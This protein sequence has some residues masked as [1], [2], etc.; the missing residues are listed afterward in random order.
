MHVRAAAL[1]VQEAGVEGGE[2]VAVG[3]RSIL[4]RRR[5]RRTTFNRLCK[6]C[7]QMY[8]DTA[9]NLSDPTAFERAYD[10]HARGV[11]R[12]AYRV[13]GNAAQAQDVVQD[14][15]LKLWR[16]P[17][18]F[19]ARRGELGSYLRLMARSRALDL[20]RE[21]QAAGRAVGSAQARRRA[22]EGR[23]RRAARPSPPSAKASGA[24]CATPCASCP[25]SSAR[26]SCSP[27]GAA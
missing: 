27:T 16:E 12:A 22:D 15:F 2:A 13:L 8:E 14:V 9:M 6:V 26:R 18:K 19:D 20:W 23:A 24:R 11:Y 10:E 17:G 25:R 5:P 3:H 7:A 1:E 4:T 21:G